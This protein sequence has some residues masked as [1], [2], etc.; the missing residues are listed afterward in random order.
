MSSIRKAGVEFYPGVGVSPDLTG[1]ASTLTAKYKKR[2]DASY[3][4]VSS[5]FVEDNPGTYSVPVTLSVV[6]DYQFII[7][8]TSDDIENLEGNILVTAASIDDVKSAVDGLQS[9]IT[10]IKDTTDLLNTT[11]L[12]NLSEQITAVDTNLGNLTSLV[13]TVDA[14]D[15]ITSIRELLI[16]IQDGGVNVDNLVNGQADVQAMLRG[17]EFLSDGT[18]SNPLYGNG[19]DDIYGK[20]ET[21]LTDVQS[22]ITTA[23]DNVISE[24]DTFK[25]SVEGKVDAVK[26]VVDANKLTLE[27]AGY[28]LSA[29]K[30]LLDALTTNVNNIDTSNT[31]VTD[32]LNDATNGLAA[33]KTTIMDK[34][35]SMDTKLDGIGGSTRARIIL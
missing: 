24:I 31:D 15:S 22:A 8:S 18:T 16:A 30:D 23:K 13:D 35:D 28:G 17:D 29:L 25:T 10:A 33:I 32:I 7:E 3:T 26:T 4:D 5:S 14:N 27:D 19:L 6:G 20:V 11:E 12:E 9:D 21:L 34:L 2:G 1:L